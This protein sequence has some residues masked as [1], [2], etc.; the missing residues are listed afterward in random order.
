[1]AFAPW[2]RHIPRVVPSDIHQSHT[3]EAVVVH[4]SRQRVAL[5]LALLAFL[6]AST[7]V[8]QSTDLYSAM[9]W[10]SIG[11]VRAGRARALA[12]VASQPN[13]FYVGFDNGGV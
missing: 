3:P 13:E 2:A 8:A 7:T 6:F 11:P 5:L 12:G 1:M 9:H 4:R 10:R